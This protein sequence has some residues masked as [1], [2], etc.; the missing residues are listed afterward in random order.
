MPALGW[1]GRFRNTGH[2]NRTQALVPVHCDGDETAQEKDGVVR[3]TGKVR[4][5]PFPEWVQMY[6]QGIPA[7]KIAG[8]V[9]APYSTVRY[10]LAR[11]A[12]KEPT[13]RTTHAGRAGRCR[14]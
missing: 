4:S 1:P 9:H 10:H 7:K 5:A 8:L 12:E 3:V 14:K 6:R 2:S 13:L 11:A